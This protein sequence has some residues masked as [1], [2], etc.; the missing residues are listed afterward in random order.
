MNI[1][2]KIVGS[3]CD[4]S[5]YHGSLGRKSDWLLRKN[6]YFNN[7]Q[8]TFHCE[9]D[10]YIFGVRYCELMFEEL[11]KNYDNC[12][13][14]LYRLNMS[15]DDMKKV[16]FVVPSVHQCRW[17][18]FRRFSYDFI[19]PCIEKG[20]ISE[21]I[22]NDIGTLL[23]IRT[24]GLMDVHISLGR[25][26]DKTTRECRFNI[27]DLPDFKNN[28]SMLEKPSLSSAFYLD[29]YKKYNISGAE[30]DTPPDLKLSIPQI[31][32]FTW[33]VIYPKIVVSRSSFC[34]I[35]SFASKGDPFLLSKCGKNCQKYYKKS[36]IIEA[37]EMMKIENTI[38]YEQK[39]M[40][41]DFIDGEYRLV[42]S[43]I[44]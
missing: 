37:R 5:G 9:P 3:T 13:E 24:E 36:H 25:S 7:L 6:R 4:F 33:N 20:I 32:G 44:F 18:E 23:F 29:L 14:L 26:W 12:S 35:G 34:E 31:D 42:Y 30:I 19:F 1:E 21:L 11:I 10:K 39:R 28:Q 22:V 16:S 43:E 15:I 17:D 2:N 38:C 8:S 41:N 40:P 27:C